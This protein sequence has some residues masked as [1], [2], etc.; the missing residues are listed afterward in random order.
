MSKEE[1][2]SPEILYG[3]ALDPNSIGPT[4]SPIPSAQILTGPT[5]PTGAT[6]PQGNTGAQG[7]TGLQGSSGLQGPA[8]IQGPTGLQ[9]P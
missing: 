5:G 1:W 6:G 4:F 2:N 3:A 9:G 7:P 8:G